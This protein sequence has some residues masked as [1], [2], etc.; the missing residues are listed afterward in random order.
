MKK[1]LFILFIVLLILNI[2]NLSFSEDRDAELWNRYSISGKL[3]N[4]FTIKFNEEFKYNNDMGDLYHHFTE[5]GLEYKVF[6]INDISLFLEADYRH[7]YEKKDNKFYVKKDDNYEEV[8][9]SI[10][11]LENRPHFNL[12]IKWNIAKLIELEDRN[13]FEYRIFHP[14]LK[15]GYEIFRYRNNLRIMS[16]EKFTPLELQPYISDE[17]FFSTNYDQY[18]DNAGKMKNDKRNGFN[19]NRLYLG[20]RGKVVKYFTPEIYYMWRKRI[21]KKD[22]KNWTNSDILGINI[23]AKF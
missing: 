5:L 7:V 6:N 22:D 18:K 12:S 10:W 4:N 3:N 15:E 20:V 13:R 17:L 8:T 11:E 16:S 14:T 2:S 9:K 1:N 23:G 21:V 19:E